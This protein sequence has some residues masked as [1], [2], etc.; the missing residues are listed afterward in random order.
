MLSLKQALG[1]TPNSWVLDENYEIGDAAPVERTDLAVG[2][3][4]MDELSVRTAFELEAQVKHGPNWCEKHQQNHHKNTK[5]PYMSGGG[6]SSEPAKSESST[7]PQPKDSDQADIGSVMESF[8]NFMGKND[9]DK[10]EFPSFLKQILESPLTLAPSTSAWMLSNGLVTDSNHLTTKGEHVLKTLSDSAENKQDQE[11]KKKYSPAKAQTLDVDGKKIE[12]DGSL[13]K[14]WQK[15][16][17]NVLQDLPIA[18][19]NLSWQTFTNHNDVIK[20]LS[21][22]LGLAMTDASHIFDDLENE[23]IIGVDISNGAYVVHALNSSKKAPSKAT[24]PET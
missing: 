12:V 10:S 1:K 21:D 13:V 17:P 22:G 16:T 19:K 18:L 23:G 2:R 7:S 20:L 24:L 14:K 11:P 15:L 5:C 8:T 9:P 6:S 3:T 4:D